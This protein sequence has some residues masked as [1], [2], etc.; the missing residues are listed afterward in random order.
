MLLLGSGPQDRRRAGRLLGLEVDG[1]VTTNAIIA[2]LDQAVL[3]RHDSTLLILLDVGCC[4]LPSRTQPSK[5]NA[6]GLER[7]L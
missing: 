6:G 1:E 4:L 2:R 7:V 5:V 3:G